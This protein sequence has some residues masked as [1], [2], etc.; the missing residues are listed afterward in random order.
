MQYPVFN[1]QLYQGADEFI[2]IAFYSDTEDAQIPFI[3]TNNDFIMT[4]KTDK[5][6][7][8]LDQLT[9]ANGRIKLG[10]VRDNLFE[11]ANE[12]AF[13]IKLHFPHE[14]TTNLQY[15]AVV[16]DLFRI[17]TDGIRELMLQGKIT[18]EKSVSYGN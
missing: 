15:P 2:P 1:F 10:I 17:N 9:V 18:I 13:A 5:S 16:Y 8:V 11:E 3:I 14:V 4:L 7:E 12:Q 6:S